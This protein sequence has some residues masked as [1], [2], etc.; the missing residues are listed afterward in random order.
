MKKFLG[1]NTDKF[2]KK[3]GRNIGVFIVI[4]ITISLGIWCFN[5][6]N[7]ILHK[8]LFALLISIFSTSFW[9]IS[10]YFFFDGDDNSKVV[11]NQNEMGKL[12]LDGVKR[13][14]IRKD[15]GPDFWSDFLSKTSI[16]ADDG[17]ISAGSTL[18]RWLQSPSY[19][20]PFCQAIVKL[21]NKRR[22]VIL[23]HHSLDLYEEDRK[24][25]IKKK[26]DMLYGTIRNE[27]IPKL[28][29]SINFKDYLMVY[30]L[31][32][33][34]PY[35]YNN[36]GETIVTGTYLFE[37]TNDENI[38]LVVDSTSPYGKNLINDFDKFIKTEGFLVDPDKLI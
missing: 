31:R 3:P 35:L 2:L 26:I 15:A 17:L 25:A 11:K 10:N 38:M 9:T 32:K 6:K 20:D 14:M 21:V 23:V 12:N 8:I 18:S 27:I 30:E 16:F 7:E 22:K 28:E 1:K 4:L 34:L 37:N 29:A 33:P 24:T 36:N 5:T 19:A 13:V